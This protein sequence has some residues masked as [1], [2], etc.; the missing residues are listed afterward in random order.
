MERRSR[1]S[2]VALY[3]YPTHPHKRIRNAVIVVS[4]SSRE[5]RAS[6]NLRTAVYRP[7]ELH[8][9]SLFP[10]FFACLHSF[11]C[12]LQVYFLRMVF[13]SHSRFFFGLRVFL[14][15]SHSF[16][17]LCFY[18]CFSLAP[19][20]SP[21]WSIDLHQELT[22][23]SPIFVVVSSLDLYHRNFAVSFS[24]RSVFSLYVL[25]CV[26]SC[27]SLPFFTSFFE[28]FFSFHE[29]NRFP[30]LCFSCF[31]HFFCV[32]WS[33]THTNAHLQHNGK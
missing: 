5:V 8:A 31:F 4:D 3:T 12:L 23:S 25:V 26:V 19:S 15:L 1:C 33:H 22:L 29:I 16:L 6:V 24:P 21:I 9:S 2:C 20:V 27:S 32:F 7:V 17:V 13:L 14:S 28:V 18:V 10:L 30:L 11:P